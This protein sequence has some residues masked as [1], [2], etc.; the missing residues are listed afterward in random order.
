[1]VKGLFDGVLDIGR[2]IQIG[3]KLVKMVLEFGCGIVGWSLK[4]W[5]VVEGYDFIMI[6]MVVE[7]VKVG[8]DFM[9]IFL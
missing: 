8:C 4:C 5:F 2:L 9:F 1:M 6:D 7:V 3:M